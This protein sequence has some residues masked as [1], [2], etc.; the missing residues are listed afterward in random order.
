MIAEV[1]R[2]D[3]PSVELDDTLQRSLDIIN[4]NEV[5]EVS[6]TDRNKFLHILR[7]I[8]LLTSDAWKISDLN[9]DQEGAF[10]FRDDHF[11]QALIKINNLDLSLIPVVN[12]EMEYM[13]AITKRKIEDY[14]C[15]SYS[16]G[17]EGSIII[18]EQALRDYSLATIANAT[19][20]EGAKI[21]GLFINP[22][23]NNLE[24]IWISIKL[25]T[26]ESGRII[27]ALER[28]GLDV[29][30]QID[31]EYKGDGIKERY[32]SFMTFLNV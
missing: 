13:G 10:I 29:I 18:I 8:D 6:V 1:L 32:E 21:L 19:E 4:A 7:E 31:N 16:V 3:I 25:N 15:D 5:T 28:H 12:R 11:F 2:E 17:S 26:L 24:K 20:Q 23:E 27:S 14:I 30:A 9:G 22:A